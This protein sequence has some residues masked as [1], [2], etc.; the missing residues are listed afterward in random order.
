ML[1]GFQLAE[2]TTLLLKGV[3]GYVESGLHIP[4][5][6]RIFLSI[7]SKLS[8]TSTCVFGEFSEPICLIGARGLLFRIQTRLRRRK[9]A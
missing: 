4:V 3:F 5:I 2:D 9:S 7:L 6:Y 1:L 8:G